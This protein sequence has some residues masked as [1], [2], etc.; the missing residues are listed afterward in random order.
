MNRPD[1]VYGR[2]LAGCCF[3]AML[4]IPVVFESHNPVSDSGKEYDKLFMN[5][6][7]SHF[8]KRIIVISDKL[9]QYYQ[10]NYDIKSN[11][12]YVA[13]D[14]ANN[15]VND[16]DP[17]VENRNALNV[18][19]TGQLYPGKGMELISEIVKKVPWAL[20]HIIGGYQEDIE[21]WRKKLYGH[22]NVKFYGFIPHGQ[23]KKYINSMDILLAPYQDKVEGHGGGDISKWMSP[24]KIFEYMAA[25]KPILC[26]DLP[27]LR[28]ILTHEDNAL[29]CEPD[30][31]DDWINSLNR[32]NHDKEL[33]EKLGRSAY[34]KFI[35]NHTWKKRAE[36]VLNNI[37]NITA[38]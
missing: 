25:G 35:E 24:L 28:E 22:S 30:N 27:V 14:A 21:K 2:N 6:L 13:H 12:L 33:K 5:L 7:Q 3:A 34:R 16:T 36:K 38:F 1:L 20:F 18:G 10:H 9:K 8:V 37:E 23:I 4:R 15:D 11:L 17:V 26:S 32:L 19:Y 31:V 29:L